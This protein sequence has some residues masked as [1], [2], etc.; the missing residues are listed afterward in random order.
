[1][2]EPDTYE[3]AISSI[4][5]TQWI[6]SMKEEYDSLINANTWTLVDKPINKNVVGCKWVYKA[7]TDAQGHVVKHKARLVAQGY[8][9]EYGIDYEEVFAPVARQ[10]TFR[11]LLAVAGKEGLTVRHFDVKNAFLNGTLDETIYMAQPKGFEVQGK[12]NMVCRLNKSIY[13]LKQAA[14]VWNK[15]LNS[16][17]IK[18]GF[19][20][21]QVDLCLYTK[22]TNSDKVYIIIYVDDIII[23]SNNARYISSMYKKLCDHFELTDLGDI[24]YYLGIKVT[25]D[26]EDIYSINQTGY[27]EKVLRTYRMEDAKESKIPL[28]IGY[29]RTKDESN[30]IE[31]KKYHSLIGALIYIATNTRVDIAASV[32][33]LSRKMNCPTEL[34]WLEAKRIRYLKGTKDLNLRLGSTKK[35]EKNI[36]VGYSDAD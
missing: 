29:K 35:E 13:G 28:D 32:S 3:E 22:V 9:Q 26:E 5:N 30:R 36:L 24:S 14:R 8:T 6:K 16:I 31:K 33:I 27:I 19:M 21:S 17:L 23:A 12:E 11:T 20:Q 7:K 10:T 18:G 15:R 1:M 2:L 34:D 25:K 4:N